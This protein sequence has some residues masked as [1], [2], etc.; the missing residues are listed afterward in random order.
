MSQKS[1]SEPAFIHSTNPYRALTMFQAV[2]DAGV[3]LGQKGSE[4]CKTFFGS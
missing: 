2:L 4:A 3:Y 1:L